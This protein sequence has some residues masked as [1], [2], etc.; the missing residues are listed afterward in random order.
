[1]GDRG[2]GK[3]VRFSVTHAPL[4]PSSIL[5]PQMLD[6]KSVPGPG[7]G[8]EGPLHLSEFSGAASKGALK[9]G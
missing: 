2:K 9:H 1:M 6:T 8:P 7:P 5:Y 3:L 4:P